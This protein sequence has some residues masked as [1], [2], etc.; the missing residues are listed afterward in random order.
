M[1][2]NLVDG[3]VKLVEEEGEGLLALQRRPG[4]Q[5]AVAQ[6]EL[7]LENTGGFNQ[8]RNIDYSLELQFWS[9]EL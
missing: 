6:A 9:S 3:C 4:E 1:R 5:V 2:T 8:S 7:N